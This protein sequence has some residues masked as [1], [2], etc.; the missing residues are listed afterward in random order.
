MAST[1]ST[2]KSQ[3]YPSPS[4][5]FLASILVRTSTQPLTKI[6]T[7]PGLS[8]N[9]PIHKN[10]QAIWMMNNS[11]ETS[12]TT[13]IA[14]IYECLSCGPSYWTR[15][16]S[17][18]MALS[19]HGGI[20][21][22]THVPGDNEISF[23]ALGLGSGM[24]D[25]TSGGAP[26]L[27]PAS[28][29]LLGE[30]K[31]VLSEEQESFCRSEATSEDEDLST[32]SKIERF[33][34]QD[35]RRMM[36][37]ELA[38]VLRANGRSFKERLETAIEGRLAM[39]GFQANQIHAMINTEERR[40][41]PPALPTYARVRR[42]F[43][44][45]GTL[46]YYDNPYTKD[47]DP[48][49]VIILREMNQEEADILFEHTRRLCSDYYDVWPDAEDVRQLSHTLRRR[50]TLANATE[51]AETGISAMRS[52]AKD[53]LDFYSSKISSYLNHIYFYLNSQGPLSLNESK[54]YDNSLQVPPF[55]AWPPTQTAITRKP[56]RNSEIELNESNRIDAALLKLRNEVHLMRESHT[57]DLLIHQLR[58]GE[59]LIIPK[60]EIPKRL[61]N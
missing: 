49:Y 5:A 55:L 41:V 9:S 27:T 11:I 15:L 7:Y 1:Q 42:E 54:R 17:S 48:N 3:I 47:E 38:T 2:R 30:S 61:L 60:H 25:D 21:H 56:L 57:L 10:Q 35:L 58:E 59:M 28:P 39:F 22:P 43:A 24:R 4:S 50:Q 12:M 44:D 32:S 13:R 8:I 40:N 51:V 29:Y 26:P 23:K 46:E 6:S 34:E 37:D 19:T 14:V 18:H 53:D 20:E 16:Q 45:I 52:G 31:H 36:R 33:T